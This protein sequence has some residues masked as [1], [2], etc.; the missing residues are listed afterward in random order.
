MEIVKFPDDFYGEGVVKFAKGQFYPLNSE[1]QS[2]VTAGFADLLKPEHMQDDVEALKAL[3]KLARDRAD[4]CMAWAQE[5]DKEAAEAEALAAEAEAAKKEP[6][7]NTDPAVQT[8]APKKEASG[9]GKK[10]EA[11]APAAEAEALAAAAAADDNATQT[12]E[13]Q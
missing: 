4:S 5:L 7:E 8:S 9:R 11:E 3:A 1:T 10:K 6:A 2:L 13:T 12:T